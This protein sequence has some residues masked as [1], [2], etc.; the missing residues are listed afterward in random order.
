MI[1]NLRGA[2]QCE[3]PND[4]IYRFEGVI[5]LVNH[6]KISLSHENFLLRGSK[7]QNTEWIY[8]V[9]THTGH[10]SRIMRNSVKSREKVS[11]LERLIAYSIL[12]IM[13][14]ECVLCSIAAAYV[15][16]W[17]KIYDVSTSSYLGDPDEKAIG[18]WEWYDY[19]TTFLK[20]FGT[21]VLLFTNLIP[22][23]LLVSVEVCKFCQALFIG[24]DICIYDTEQD[25][26]TKVQ[27]SNLNEELG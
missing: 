7:L 8:G 6:G 21:W 18:S 4:Q 20:A 10:D 27:S 13:L 5:K 9:V 19:I 25:L 1:E 2:V 22:I 17:E 14:F 15:T 16:V 11:D 3:P 26:P 23:S 24:W 12:T